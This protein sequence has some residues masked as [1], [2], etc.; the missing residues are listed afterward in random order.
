VISVISTFVDLIGFSAIA[1]ELAG[2][3]DP[4]TSTRRKWASVTDLKAHGDP[5]P[6][7]GAVDR[8]FRPWFAF[9]VDQ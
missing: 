9:G 6:S 8:V 5:Q 2:K 4:W 3:F 7:E 1:L